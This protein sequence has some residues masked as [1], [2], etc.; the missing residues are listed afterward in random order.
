MGR[1]VRFAKKSRALGAGT[2]GLA[3]LYQKRRI[4]FESEVARALNIE[5]HSFIQ[6]EAIKA[7]KQ[8]AEKYGEPEWCEG[9]AMRNTHL[10]ATAPTRTNSVISGAISQGIE[11]LE[12]NL[13]VAKQAKG[14]FVRRNPFLES[15]LEEKGKN[16]EEVWDSLIESRG[17]VK[18]LDFLSEEEKNIFLTAREINQLEI[19]RQAAE[20]QPYICQAQSLNLFLDEN[21]EP[22]YIWLLHLAAWRYGLK[23][24][25][26]LRSSSKLLDRQKDSDAYNNIVVT[27]PGCP[28]CKKAKD[29]LKTRG[30]KYIE[31]PK[32][33]AIGSGFFRESHKTFPQIYIDKT[34]IGGYDDLLEYF[35]Q[36]FE[37][38]SIDCVACEG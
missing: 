10:L 33:K 28:F 25:Y 3:A 12:S 26:Y 1:A 5:I 34:F 11:P 19:I 7:S 32:E 27:K 13:F 4:P 38:S 16:T 2:M 23:S 18:H 14:T 8:L 15:L 35:D 30:I 21:A 22:D 29:F 6:S 31:M 9:S 20:R 37:E 36:S 24:L 17:S